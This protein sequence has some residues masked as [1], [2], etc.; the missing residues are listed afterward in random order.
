MKRYWII[1]LV[2]LIT[3]TAGCDQSDSISD[4]KDI[5]NTGIQEQF[6]IEATPSSEAEDNIYFDSQGIAVGD[7]FGNFTVIDVYLDDEY[8][9]EKV[10]FEGT[11]T[12]SGELIPNI[13]GE[14]RYGIL[15][16]KVDIINNLP[17][18]TTWE[19]VNFDDNYKG[20][21]RVLS[22]EEVIKNIGEDRDSL[23]WEK[24]E[25]GIDIRCKI[26]AVFNS[27]TYWVQPNTDV[28]SSLGLK[29]IIFIEEVDY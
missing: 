4:K 26:S 17:V 27:Y 24:A 18:P 19:P 15:I 16:S 25:M 6:P 3:I 21:F 20:Y 13:I 12:L 7:K 23:I 10:V 28:S 2:F 9:M 29:E 11:F 1:L 5:I 8:G 22:D 14:S